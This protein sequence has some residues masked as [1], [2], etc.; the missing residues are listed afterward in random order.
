MANNLNVNSVVISGNITTPPRFNKEYKILNLSVA[1]NNPYKDKDGNWKND[2]LYIDVVVNRELAEWGAKN[3][4]VKDNVYIT[5]KLK[6]N[7]YTNKDNVECKTIKLIADSLR[8]VHK[9]GEQESSGKKNDGKTQTNTQT[10]PDS[11]D[12]PF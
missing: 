11:E 10:A 3:L 9:F 2:P 4:A 8:L 5:G 1:A 6:N 7:V 12:I